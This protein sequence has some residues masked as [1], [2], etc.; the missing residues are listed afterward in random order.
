M[1][2]QLSKIWLRRKLTTHVAE[3]AKTL[4]KAFAIS[5]CYVIWAGV[6]EQGKAVK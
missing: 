3:H 2:R 6:Q 5:K 1:T 4:M